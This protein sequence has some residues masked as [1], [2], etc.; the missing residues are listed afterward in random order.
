MSMRT[1]AQ[2]EMQ[3]SNFG[4]SFVPARINGAQAKTVCKVEGDGLAP[5]WWRV[6][7]NRLGREDQA[8]P[9]GGGSGGVPS[10]T[11]LSVA[12]YPGQGQAFSYSAGVM[13]NTTYSNGTWP[14]R[15]QPVG[16][17][18]VFEAGITASVQLAWGSGGQAL[19]RIIA[20]W[21]YLGGSVVLYGSY[22]EVIAGVNIVDQSRIGPREMPQYSAFIAPVDGVT[23]Q[24]SGELSITQRVTLYPADGALRQEGGSVYV[25]EFAR[26]VRVAITVGEEPGYW[27]VNNTSGGVIPK[28]GYPTAIYVFS[29]ESGR[30]VDQYY[31][32]VAEPPEWMAVPASAVLLTIV[33]T[34]PTAANG[35]MQGL[36]HWRVAP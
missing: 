16:G 28:S 30:A 34:D 6:T 14:Q 9:L 8:S 23:T 27:L 13:G 3:M 29:D 17:S 12:E 10:D 19:G 31:V 4:D 35:T 5:R 1:L 2:S 18:F 21:P 24:D 15:A 32:N 20:D 11:S 22:V 7:L 25:P 33:Q 36:V 26:R